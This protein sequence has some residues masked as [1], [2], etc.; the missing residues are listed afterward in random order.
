MRN[1]SQNF[2]PHFP[3]L[4]TGVKRSRYV[5]FYRMDTPTSLRFYPGT[6]SASPE[7]LPLARY[8]PPLPPGM[9]SAWLAENIPAG[10]WLLD[11][12]GA[13]PALALEAARAGYR[14][15]VA[16][17]NPILT[18]LLET[19][20][21]ASSS[22]DFQSALAELAMS[23]RGEERLEV[24][25]RSLYQTTCDI[26]GQ[27]VE[28]QAF[29]WRKGETQPYA[30]LYAC[31]KC[32]ETGEHP[33]I[34]P[35]L[36]RLAA[37][38]S[39][40]MQRSRAL[41]RVLLNDEEH[42]ADVEE[43]LEHYLPRPLYVLFT[44]AN[45]IEGLGL[46]PAR[47]RLLQALMISLFDAGSTLWPWPG[48]RARPKQLLV[49]PQF[50]EVNLWTALEKAGAEWSHQPG[51]VPVTRWPNLPPQA[52]GICL[53]RGRVKALMPLPT[54]IEP[55]AVV[56]VFPRPN[57]AFW[58]LSVLWTGWL[59][60][61][62]AALP[63]RNVLDRRRYDWNWHTS[64][65]HS[66]LAPVASSLPAETPFFGLLP[67]LAPGFLSAVIAAAEAAGFRL[68]GLAMRADSD[69]RGDMDLAQAVWRPVSAPESERA[70]GKTAPLAETH[71]A[72]QM[73]AAARAAIRADLLARS[74][75][76]S[77]LV[78]YAAGL[79]A[80]AQGGCIPRS[81]SSIPGDLLTRV[82]AALA[83]TFSDRSL[84]KLYGGPGEEE[85]GLW[86]LVGPDEDRASPDQ[87]QMP[88]A[89]RVEIEVVR[90]MQKNAVF[91][92][93]ELDQWLC[94]RLTGLL[95]PPV[96]LVRACLES[97]RGEHPREAGD[98]PHAYQRDGSC[99][100]K[101]PSGHAHRPGNPGAQAGLHPTQRGL[102]GDVGG[103]RPGRLVVLLHGLQHH[104]PV[105]A[106]GRRGKRHGGCRRD[107]RNQ[108]AQRDRTARQPRAPA[109]A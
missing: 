50:R 102:P 72:G 64:A 87:A 90:F 7:V 27:R 10:S 100:K 97:L 75:P 40:R 80:L 57:Q 36:D 74:E 67:E 5:Y 103:K 99:A 39:D 33:V 17:N 94:S 16:S 58:T 69:G 4:K 22:A 20:A 45:K 34:Q 82:Q 2:D 79:A 35:D 41:Q 29:L 73:E 62:E 11:P 108:P 37:M 89:D 93:E 53:Y 101:R 59:W 15:L 71:K 98:L 78:E 55:K 43:A 28:A 76:A 21:G 51:P 95:T 8:L 52:G 47:T 81:L 48:G 23:R 77:Y 9:A 106:Q 56:S 68:E 66:A 86:S 1:S 60:G 25:L 46:P 38:G 91:H 44:L 12:L 32:G 18:F 54:G 88:L 83:R 105:C 19:L 65:I 84:L 42:R 6:G 70:A 63:L 14:V 26:C 13:S 96:D 92:F 49:P 30:R 31:P 109:H 3:A 24:H 104:Q 61:A 107:C 85:R